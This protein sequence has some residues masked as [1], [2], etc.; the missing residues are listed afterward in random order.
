MLGTAAGLVAGG[1]S[2][3]DFSLK[4][5]NYELEARM[6]EQ[7]REQVGNLLA[8]AQLLTPAIREQEERKYEQ[9]LAILNQ[10]LYRLLRLTEHADLYQRQELARRKE[11]VEVQEF[12]RTL[13]AQVEGVSQNLDVAFQWE[14]QGK[15]TTVE[16]DRTLL[17]RLI[18]MLLED[19]LR[20]AGRG[21]RAGLRTAGDENRV[22]IT[23]WDDGERTALPGREPP[24]ES[25][26][27]WREKRP[28]VELARA[29][30]AANGGALVYERGE[31]RGMRAV[32][33]FPVARNPEAFHTPRMGYDAT[34]G[35]Q[36]LLVELSDLLPYQAY[37]PEELE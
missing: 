1:K 2:W 11:L 29:M 6:V 22:R 12:C 25:P 18:L 19:A 34:G 33:S 35:F 16:A 15:E 28:E 5:D 37:L 20:A 24:E 13:G 8:A 4:K 26:L 21:G 23:V 36:T 3:E 31:E 17:E 9:Y 32:L 30:A 14:C 27:L 10:G 7:L